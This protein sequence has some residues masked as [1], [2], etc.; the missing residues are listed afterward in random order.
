MR[1]F[2]RA[3]YGVDVLADIVSNTKVSTITLEIM[4][5]YITQFTTILT[6]K[7]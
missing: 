4:I 5:T 1:S 3:I 6:A 2:D 7:V